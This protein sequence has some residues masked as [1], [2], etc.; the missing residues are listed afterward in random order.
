[1]CAG[2]IY[3]HPHSQFAG[4]FGGATLEEQRGRGIYSALLSRRIQEAKQRGRRFITTGASPMS[5]PVLEKVGFRL[6]SFAY[7]YVWKGHPPEPE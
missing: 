3:F 5:R 7:D 4:L 6:V 1:M 2:W